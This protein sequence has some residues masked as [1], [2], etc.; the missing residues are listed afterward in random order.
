LR[1]QRQ[2]ACLFLF[3]LLLFPLNR[4]GLQFFQ[5]PNQTG[6]W[7]GFCKESRVS[8]GGVDDGYVVIRGEKIVVELKGSQFADSG[9]QLEQNG[10]VVREVRELHPRRRR[11]KGRQ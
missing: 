7:I 10:G 11:N 3:N 5:F 9:K 8:P 1:L 2:K 4:I 6:L